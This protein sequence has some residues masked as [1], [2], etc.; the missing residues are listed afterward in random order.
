MR[1]TLMLVFIRGHLRE[2]GS[3]LVVASASDSHLTASHL[4]DTQQRSP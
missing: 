1:P 4:A 2:P 3:M